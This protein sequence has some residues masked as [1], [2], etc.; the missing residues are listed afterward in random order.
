[1]THERPHRPALRVEQ[2]AEE[3][4]RE[5]RACRLDGDVAAAVLEAAGARRPRRRNNLRPAGLSEREVEVARLVAAGWSN[6]EIAMRLVISRRTAETTC[7]TSTPRSE[8]RAGP[9][10]RSSCTS[11]T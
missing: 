1:M 10:S 5:V 4:Q 8:S 6:P 7:R 2:A 11:T 9:G 3:V